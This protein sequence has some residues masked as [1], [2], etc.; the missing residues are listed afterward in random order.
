MPPVG[1]VRHRL[2][3]HQRA[4]DGLGVAAAERA[5][6]EPL[7]P[8]R[9]RVVVGVVGRD[10][11]RRVEVRREPGQHERNPLARLRRE[12]GD[13]AHV[14]AADVDRRSEGD[15]VRAGDRDPGVVLEPAH[16]GDDRAVVE[17]EHELH[18]HRHAPL[19]PLDD[20]DDVG[21]VAARRHEVGHADAAVLGVEVELV[22][23]R[24][25]AVAAL[26]A[27]DLA[28]GREQ[29]AAVALVPEQGGEARARVEAREAEPVD[30]AVAPDERRGLQVADQ[31][32]VLDPHQSASGERAEAAVG[33]A[34]ER[35]L[36][37]IP[38]VA[39]ERRGVRVAQ[40]GEG[41]CD[42]LEH[43][44][45]VPVRLLG[46]LALGGVVRPLGLLRLAQKLG[47][48]LDE[49]V[50]L[51]AD[52]LAEAVAAEDHSELPV[53]RQVGLRG[54]LPGQLAARPQRTGT[55]LRQRRLVVDELADRGGQPVDVV[56]RR[57]RAPRRRPAPARRGR[58]RRRRPP[59][60]RRRARAAARRSG[61]A[62]GG[63]GRRRRSTRR[64]RG[65]SP[66]RSGTRRRRRR[67][68]AAPRARA[69]RRRGRARAA[70]TGA[71]GRV[72]ARCGRRRARV[73]IA[74][75]DGVG[76]HAQLLLRDAERGQRLAAALASGRRSARSG[77]TPG[78][79]GRSS[80]PSA[81]AGGRAR[82]AR[83]ARGG[84]AATSRARAPPATARGRRPPAWRRG[85][86]GRTDARAP[87]AA[88]AAASG[89]RAATRAGRRARGAGSR[90]GRRP[91]RSES[92]T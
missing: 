39:V 60:R 68:A 2:Q 42:R 5:G 79:R 34:V 30:R 54:R 36:V 21:S 9:A 28:V 4:E 51:A 45:V 1:R 80:R 40:L 89:R 67:R 75:R 33:G 58:R 56:R 90:P 12:L 50:E 49:E 41:V 43:E 20:P 86:P 35:V 72:R 92:G 59:A 52:Q 55:G 10:R 44:L 73:R 19:E 66:P 74:R 26:D 63:R 77:R 14:L 31:P 70:C 25:L 82:S 84:A 8:E 62:R 37:R 16:P 76:D 47:L 46:K 29:P 32:V 69:R 64:A 13:G 71:R 38:R 15:R 7:V 91:G 87:S 48:V 88:R 53:E 24:V 81:R 6:D 23:E 3:H 78:A 83:A 22:H 61:R 85:A 65:R 17:A 11:A 18:P 27:L 57:R